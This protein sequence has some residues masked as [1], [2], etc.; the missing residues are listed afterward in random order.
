MCLEWQQITAAVNF[1]SFRECPDKKVV[2]S[3]DREMNFCGQGQY[4]CSCRG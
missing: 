1:I 3:E 4:D 2:E